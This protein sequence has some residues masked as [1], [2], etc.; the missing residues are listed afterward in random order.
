LKTAFATKKPV[1]E[2]W[3]LVLFQVGGDQDPDLDTSFVEE[4][5]ELPWD[6]PLALSSF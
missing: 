5:D 6:R 3:V 4:D 1:V 2:T